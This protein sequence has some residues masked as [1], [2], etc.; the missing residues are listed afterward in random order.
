MKTEPKVFPSQEFW[1]AVYIYSLEHF[2]IEYI[3][4]FFALNIYCGLL[5]LRI[6]NHFLKGPAS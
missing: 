1:Y 5:C 4:D 2:K 6:D 3:N